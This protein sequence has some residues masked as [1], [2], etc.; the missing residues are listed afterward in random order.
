MAGLMRAARIE[1]RAMT[2][3]IHVRL[4]GISV[5][6]LGFL[7]PRALRAEP[8]T[9][10]ARNFSRTTIYHSPQK[11]GYTCWVGA[12]IMPDQSLMV[13]FKQATGPVKGRERAPKEILEANRWLRASPQRDFTGLKLAN[14]YL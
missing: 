11:P 4:L 10:T 7:S 1:G 9:L 12:W 5:I 6:A 3:R 14:V 8:E 2:R 13:T